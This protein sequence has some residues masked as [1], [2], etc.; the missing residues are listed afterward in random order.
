MLAMKQLIRAANHLRSAMTASPIRAHHNERESFQCWKRSEQGLRVARRRLRKA[1]GNGLAFIQPQLSNDLRCQ[2]ETVR[3]AIDSLVDHFTTKSCEAPNLALLIAELR[4]LE[5]EF[6]SLKIDW[7]EK[8]ISVT[9]ESITLQDVYLGPFSINLLWER[10][11]RSRDIHA[12]DVVALNPNPADSN[13]SVTHPHVCDNQLCPGRAAYPLSTALS[14]GRIADAFCLIRSVLTNY[15][16]ESPHVSLDAWSGQECHDCGCCITRDAYYCQ[17]CGDD[18]CAD[19]ISNCA[20]CDATR[21][22]D[23][24]SA[25]FVCQE[26]FC[27]NCVITSSSQ[28][29]CCADCIE[30]CARCQKQFAETD[31]SSPKRLCPD[32]GRRAKKTTPIHEK[33]DHDERTSDA[34]ATVEV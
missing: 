28:R 11:T 30:P 18:F 31:L 8:S 26:R 6:G 14:Q 16:P 13:E 9:T 23:C 17:D 3:D 29:T 2:L 34:P 24:L 20:G 32:C 1:R 12:F 4:Q 25:C 10:L 15:N 5:E 33:E 7:A 22:R 19:C 27:S 21:C